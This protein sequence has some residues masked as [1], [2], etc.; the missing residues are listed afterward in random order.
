MVIKILFAILSISNGSM[1]DELVGIKMISS[2]GMQVRF[3]F[4]R[5]AIP[6]SPWAGYWGVA[7]SPAKS[8]IKSASITYKGVRLSLPRS[9][10]TDLANVHTIKHAVKGKTLIVIMR[11]SDASDGF[12]AQF[13]FIDGRLVRRKVQDGELPNQFWEETKYVNRTSN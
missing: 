12:E 11:G 10:F 7:D 9:S 5:E 2:L 8:V 6:A 4:Q 1:Q 3:E 13:V